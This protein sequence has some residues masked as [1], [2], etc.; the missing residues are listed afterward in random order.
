MS[1]EAA[2]RGRVG[3]RAF[4]ISLLSTLPIIAYAVGDCP[5]RE[6]MALTADA[7]ATMDAKSE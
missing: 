5:F 6:Q 3:S 1:N 7:N 2:I 4:R